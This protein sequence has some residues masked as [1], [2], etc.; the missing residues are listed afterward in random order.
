[1]KISLRREGTHHECKRTPWRLGDA[2]KGGVS[3]PKSCDKANRPGAGPET[4][5]VVVSG[6]FCLVYCWQ[7]TLEG[8]KW[9]RGPR[10]AS[11][12]EVKHVFPVDR[13]ISGWNQG[14]HSQ[15]SAV[16]MQQ[17]FSKVPDLLKRIKSTIWTLSS[18][19][20]GRN[21]RLERTASSEIKSQRPPGWEW[22]KWPRGAHGAH[23]LVTNDWTQSEK[24]RPFSAL[25]G[26]RN[27]SKHRLFFNTLQS[28]TWI[29][30][31]PK[32]YSCWG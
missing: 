26:W 22:R 30:L 18:L 27:V 32:M 8:A 4:K 7:P 6:F 29:Y 25:L 11:L 16:W 5:E 23:K 24:L 19:L 1:M 2:R 20:I 12:D 15:D 21:G 9:L 28:L 14:W 17:R 31:V 3:F 13:P 10:G